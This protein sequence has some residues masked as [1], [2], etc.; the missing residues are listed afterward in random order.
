ME[1]FDKEHIDILA[2]CLVKDLEASDWEKWLEI[3]DNL[4]DYVF[5]ALCDKKLCYL[6]SE[7]LKKLFFFESISDTVL[8]K[9]HDI[10]LNA[11]TLLYKTDSNKECRDNLLH[12]F[13]ELYPED[14]KFR[15]Y[16]YNIIKEFSEKHLQMFLK[17]NLVDFMNHIAR[18]RRSKNSTTSSMS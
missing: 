1:S 7:I 14:K 9:S 13:D 16:F 5:L 8:E 12:F 4:K 2:A 6:A 10:F 11:L 18:E 15:E 3:Y 17:S